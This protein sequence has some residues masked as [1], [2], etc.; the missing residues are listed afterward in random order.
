[1]TT[2]IYHKHRGLFADRRTTDGS[3]LLPDARKI[4]LVAPGGSGGDIALGALHAGASPEDAI[5]ATARFDLG[6]SPYGDFADGANIG[7]F[8]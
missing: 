1:M 5:K 4:H 3:S 8:S 6:T 2:V 7:A